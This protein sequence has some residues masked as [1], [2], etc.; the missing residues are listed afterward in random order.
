[1]WNA[2][3]S[4]MGLLETFCFL[5]GGSADISG[6]GG[7]GGSMKRTYTRELA[8]SIVVIFQVISIQ[9]KIY[10]HFIFFCVTRVIPVH[11]LKDNTLSESDN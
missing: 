7:C 8:L 3:S 4:L 5:V 11:T 2:S 1:M 9:R 6:Y 10:R